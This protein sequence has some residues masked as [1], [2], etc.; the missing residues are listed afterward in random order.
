MLTN[1]AINF[2]KIP[3]L[4]PSPV[5][6]FTG[7]G[8]Y[9][10]GTIP[11][12]LPNGEQVYASEVPRTDG[13]GYIAGDINESNAIGIAFGS[14]DHEESASDYTL[15]NQILGLIGSVTKTYIRDEETGKHI[16]RLDCTVANNNETDVTIR[17]IGFFSS[18][19]YATTKGGSIG[20]SPYAC[21]MT[22][23]TVLEQPITIPAGEARVIRYEFAY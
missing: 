9:T 6:F 2:L 14:D 17:E 15:G 16:V 5:P 3:L 1:N 12:I 4:N 7:S 19:Y 13:S 23:R 22:D 21:V 18:Y 8:Q 10:F 20:K 11:M